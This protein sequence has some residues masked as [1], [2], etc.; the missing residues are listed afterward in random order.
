MAHNAAAGGFGS[1]H[2]RNHRLV[3][4]NMLS[5]RIRPAVRAVPEKHKGG[6]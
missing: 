4:Q 6:R 5:A 2:S 3:L 1:K